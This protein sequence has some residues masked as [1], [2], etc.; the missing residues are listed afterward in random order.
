MSP[1]LRIHISTILVLSIGWITVAELAAEEELRQ[2]P[3]LLFTAQELKDLRSKSKEYIPEP[4]VASLKRKAK[5]NRDDP[6]FL[7]FSGLWFQDSAIRVRA[8]EILLK[9]TPDS[10]LKT[11][12]V[13]TGSHIRT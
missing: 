7:A 4:F 8:K 3:F 6:G 1:S 12:T 9:K 11:Y 2:H 5:R 10:G 13:H